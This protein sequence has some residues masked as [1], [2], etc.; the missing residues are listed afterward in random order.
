MITHEP[1]QQWT[2]TL[3]TWSADGKS[4]TLAVET[5]QAELI[6]A[7]SQDAKRPEP[8]VDIQRVT[9][10]LEA[11][12][13]AM[14]KPVRVHYA[15]CNHLEHQFHLPCQLSGETLGDLRQVTGAAYVDLYTD[16]APGGTWLHMRW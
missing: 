12:L 9:D 7:A 2:N 11:W 15:G 4:V 13:A 10:Q 8:Q 14:G 16:L 3:V 1:S 5:W 6:L